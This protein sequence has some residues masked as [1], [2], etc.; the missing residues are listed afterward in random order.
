MTEKHNIRNGGGTISNTDFE[1]VIQLL[2]E[3]YREQY[4]K[5]KWLRDSGR[6][7]DAVDE[8]SSYCDQLENA[9]D[10]LED[11]PEQLENLKS[12]VKKLK[13]FEDV[14]ETIARVIKKG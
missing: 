14:V 4:D 6:E 8:L 12:E 9:V 10:F 1:K 3:E 11:V 2:N 7:G 13:H 5:L